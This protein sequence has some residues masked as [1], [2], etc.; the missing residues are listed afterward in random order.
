LEDN[1]LNDATLLGL[2]DD[3]YDQNNFNEY[4]IEFSRE[5]A[6]TNNPGKGE[7]VSRKTDQV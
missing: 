2:L 1:S 6:K 4:M 5:G 7:I 3:S